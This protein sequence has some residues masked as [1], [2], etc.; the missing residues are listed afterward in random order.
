MEIDILPGI[1]HTDR[2][3]LEKLHKLGDRQQQS[4]EDSA[5]LLGSNCAEAEGVHHKEENYDKGE[6]PEGPGETLSP[7]ECNY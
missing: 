1:H 2:R 3:N 5:K 6:E 7:V 4:Q